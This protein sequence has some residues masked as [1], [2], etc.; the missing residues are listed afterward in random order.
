MKDDVVLPVLTSTVGLL[1]VLLI[2]IALFWIIKSRSDPVEMKLRRF[3]YGGFGNVYHGQLDGTPVPVKLYHNHRQ[4]PS[5]AAEF[6]S[7]TENY[8]HDGCEP[9]ILHRDFNSSNILLSE[10]SEAKFWLCFGRQLNSIS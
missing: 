8:L 6:Q 5:A 3:S 7:E 2:A 4:H 9:P 1:G 10:N